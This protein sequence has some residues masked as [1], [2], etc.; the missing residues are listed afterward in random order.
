MADQAGDLELLGRQHLERGVEGHQEVVVGILIED[1]HEALLEHGRRETVGQDHVTARRVG[2]TLH[3]QQ[4]DLIETTSK[5]VDHVAIMRRASS[6]TIVELT[7]ARGRR[8]Q[9]LKSKEGMERLD[10]RFRTLTFNAFL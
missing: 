4:A 2:Q 7:F 1:A 8:Q 9:P 5:D 3:L 6:E 10:G